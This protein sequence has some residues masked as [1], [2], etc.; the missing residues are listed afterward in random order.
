[1]CRLHVAYE[2]EEYGFDPFDVSDRHLYDP[3]TLMHRKERKDVTFVV[4]RR[5]KNVLDTY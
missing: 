1:M 2:S 4:R 5:Y 3:G